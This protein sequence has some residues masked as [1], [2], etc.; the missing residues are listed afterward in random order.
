MNPKG[1][2][3]DFTLRDER[4]VSAEQVKRALDRKERIVLLD[5][6]PES[7]WIQF[8]IPGAIPFPYY[9]ESHAARIPKD[10]TWV[11]AYCACPHH[12]SGEVVNALRRDGYPKTAVLDE[13]ILV[14]RNLGYPI[15]GEAA[16]KP[17]PLTSAP[18]KPARP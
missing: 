7:D 4:Y 18:A 13:G 9:E 2:H 14:W 6:R 5:A 15:A 17:P 8:R 3:P 16:G 1:A 12:A 10:G 11:V